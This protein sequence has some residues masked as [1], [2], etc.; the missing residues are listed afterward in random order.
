[1]KPISFLTALLLVYS[2]V[3]A[4]S[5]APANAELYFISPA[6]GST[7]QNPVTIR[8]GLKNIGVA[9]A[10]VNKA[11]TG[12]HHL[13]IDSGLPPLD[14]PIPSDARHRHFGKGQTET[15]LQLGPGKHTLQ[16]LLG[17][18]AHTPHVPPVIS[19]PI[20]ITVK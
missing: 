13:L 17:D 2:G 15:T 3:L 16:L 6:D 4:Q 1:M 7:V 5:P 8:F 11:D 9:P 12:H 10:G 14:K 20:S 19:R 18:F